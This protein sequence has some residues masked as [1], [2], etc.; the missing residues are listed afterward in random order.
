MQLNQR[1][2]DVYLG[3]KNF[4]KAIETKKRIL[5]Q[6]F[7][8]NSTQLKAKEITSLADIYIQKKEDKTAIT[9]LSESYALSV[10]KRACTGSKNMY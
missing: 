10:G 2:T 1:I 6:G 9:L 3:E 5:N 4:P 8:Q 7:V